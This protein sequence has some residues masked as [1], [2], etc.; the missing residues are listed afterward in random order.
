MNSKSTP[1]QLAAMINQSEESFTPKLGFTFTVDQL[2]AAV[3]S[4]GSNVVLPDNSLVEAL[5]YMFDRMKYEPYCLE[6]TKAFYLLPI[7]V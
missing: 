1:N 2:R 6:V 5:D 3:E 7:R 4:P